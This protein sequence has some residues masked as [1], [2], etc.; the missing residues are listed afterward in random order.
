MRASPTT[1][2]TLSRSCSPSLGKAATPWTDMLD[3]R[4]R[5]YLEQDDVLLAVYYCGFRPTNTETAPILQ[6]VEEVG[7]NKPSL[8]EQTLDKFFTEH[9]VTLE[10]LRSVQTRWA[11]HDLPY[12][13]GFDHMSSRQYFIM[14]CLWSLVPYYNMRKMDTFIGNYSVSEKPTFNI[15]KKLVGGGHTFIMACF[16]IGL[17]LIAAGAT[18]VVGILELASVSIMLFFFGIA[19][20]SGRETNFWSRTGFLLRHSFYWRKFVLDHCYFPSFRCDGRAVF[21]SLINSSGGGADWK[22]SMK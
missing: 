17:I 6:M 19:A 2:H 10:F 7:P 3:Q 1:F 21:S 11:E 9:A 15:T 12:H 22:V 4:S 20:Q 13:P 5:G 8:V 16:Y 14:K 18:Q